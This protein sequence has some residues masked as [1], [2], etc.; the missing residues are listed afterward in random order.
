MMDFLRGLRI[1]LI[2][3]VA[4]YLLGHGIPVVVGTYVLPEKTVQ[5]LVIKGQE[6]DWDKIDNSGAEHR[7][8]KGE[9]S[10]YKDHWGAGFVTVLAGLLAIWIVWWIVAVIMILGGGGMSR[11][12]EEREQGVKRKDI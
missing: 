2:V 1:V 11:K 4:L 10:T 7:Y 12:N 3:V 8:D 5:W 9:L 6:Q